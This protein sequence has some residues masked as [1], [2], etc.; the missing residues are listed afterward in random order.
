MSKYQKS[1]EQ[2]GIAGINTRLAHIGNKPRDYHGIVNPPVVRASTVLFP[3]FETMR[4][5]TQKY[6]Y[7]I[8]GTP[9]TDA[10]AGALNEL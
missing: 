5:R 8:S 4:E 7:G 1:A 10:L 9:T 6:S 3:D 2:S